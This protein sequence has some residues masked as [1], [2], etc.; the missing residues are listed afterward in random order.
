M[1]EIEIL[2]A[3]I[4]HLEDLINILMEQVRRLANDR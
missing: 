4:D 1:S 3:R 2:K